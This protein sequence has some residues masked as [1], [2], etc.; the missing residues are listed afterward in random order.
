MTGVLVRRKTMKNG[1]S[2]VESLTCSFARARSRP[3]VDDFKMFSEE[4]QDDDKTSYCAI[5]YPW[6][7]WR[8]PGFPGEHPVNTCQNKDKISRDC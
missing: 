8:S 3:P 2:L 1:R 5:F 7:S 4:R 6:R